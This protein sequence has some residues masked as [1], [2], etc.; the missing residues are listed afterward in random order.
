MIH[1]GRPKS[2]SNGRIANEIVVAAAGLVFAFPALYVIWRNYTLGADFVTI[3]SSPRVLAALKRSLYL[4]LSVTATAAILATLLAWLVVRTD[5]YGRRFARG[6]LVLPLVFPS[7]LG[8]AAF[9]RT[10]SSGGLIDRV[11]HWQNLGSF[12]YNVRGFWGAW[13]IL[14]LFTFPYVFLPVCARLERVS[15]AVEESAR[16]LGDSALK[17]FFKIVWPQISSSVA[18]GSM[19]VFLYTVSDYGAV[20]MMRYDTLTRAI[21]QNYLARPDVAFALSLLLLI[22]AVSAVALQRFFAE[23]DTL[24]LTKNRVRSQSGSFRDSGRNDSDYRGR[25]LHYRLGRWRWPAFGFVSAVGFASVVAPMVSIIDWAARGVIQHR[26]GRPLSLTNERI[27][28]ATLNSVEIS[29][30]GSFSAVL[31]V[32]PVAYL[33]AR[34]RSSSASF[35]H[36]IIISGYA[37]PGILIAL[38]L[39][40]WTLRAGTLGDLLYDSMPLFV[41]AYALRFGSLALGVLAASFASVPRVLFQASSLLG[42]SRLRGAFKVGLPMVLPGVIAAL[43]LVLLSVMKEL[44]IALFISPLGYR[45]L[46]GRIFSSF[47]EAFVVEAGVMACILVAVSATLTWLLLIRRAQHRN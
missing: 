28:Q 23:T 10:L 14:S 32:A 3:A 12:G 47:E 7:F 22:V 37:I 35:A 33:L 34:R 46:A 5:L 45:T 18:S 20:Q 42:A 36:L 26:S 44:P 4:A 16:L 9:I 2:K 15:I 19:L 24:S 21:A 39:R 31:A 1:D 6:W 27:F 29:I 8:A 38:A 11:L 17:I 30:L 25:Y 40:F 13:L 41:A 43:G